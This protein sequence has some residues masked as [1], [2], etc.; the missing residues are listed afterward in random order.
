MMHKEL[1]PSSVVPD[2]FETDGVGPAFK[3]LE[4]FFLSQSLIADSSSDEMTS[5]LS[6]NLGGRILTPGDSISPITGKSGDEERKKCDVCLAL[7]DGEG[8]KALGDAIM[9]AANL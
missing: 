4:R 8:R 5:A 2:V 9:S 6:P 3:V 1:S 7:R